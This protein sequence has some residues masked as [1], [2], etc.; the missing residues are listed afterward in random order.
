M[1]FH[2]FHTRSFPWPA[3]EARIKIRRF[4]NRRFAGA[5]HVL[6]IVGNLPTGTEDSL[7]SRGCLLRSR[8]P[9]DRHAFSEI[10]ASSFSGFNSPSEFCSHAFEAGSTRP[11][12]DTLLLFAV[13]SV[14]IAPAFFVR[15]LP[16][17]KAFA[18]VA[19]A[20]KAEP[21]VI[22]CPSLM[23]TI[24]L[25]PHEGSVTP[26]SKLI[27]PVLR[28]FLEFS[29]IAHQQPRCIRPSLRSFG[30][31]HWKAAAPQSQDN[32]RIAHHP[33]AI[34]QKCEDQSTGEPNGDRLAGNGP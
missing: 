23:R 27:L 7:L 32:V 8:P 1:A 16:L 11:K 6:F 2:A 25:L 12:V 3:L 29:Q 28:D 19:Y 17:R 4:R 30:W 9:L 22:V 31:G 34:S 18:M 14:S 24:P 15:L 10:E 26:E 5:Q 13:V 21:A 20:S 33:T